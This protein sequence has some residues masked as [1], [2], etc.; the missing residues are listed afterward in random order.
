[1]S[2]LFGLSPDEVKRLPIKSV[3]MLLQALTYLITQTKKDPV[4][5]QALRKMINNTF[6]AAEEEGADGTEGAVTKSISEEDLMTGY[7]QFLSTL[8]EATKATKFNY[9]MLLDLDPTK[10]MNPFFT[11]L[12]T[13]FQ[14]ETLTR[15]QKQGMLLFLKKLAEIA[16]TNN[17]IAQALTK[18]VRTENTITDKEARTVVNTE[19]PVEESEKKKFEVLLT[20]A[21]SSTTVAALPTTLQ[22]GTD[23]KDLDKFS[24]CIGVLNPSFGGTWEQL[25]AKVGSMKVIDFLQKADI[26]IEALSKILLQNFPKINKAVVQQLG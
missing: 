7:K 3:E 22:L 5:R 20:E 13:T 11:Q 26:S 21:A 2:E 1:M 14:M 6:S 15:M 24:K 9:K 19:A 10:L 4:L 23:P 17:Q 16:D 25:K 8:N 12:V 18:I